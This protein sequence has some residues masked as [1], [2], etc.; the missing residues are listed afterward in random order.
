MTEMIKQ[1]ASKPATISMLQILKNP[2]E[3]IN[4]IKREMEENNTQ[5]KLL[6]MKSTISEIK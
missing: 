4:I 6:E 1:K 2:E 3:N 5:I